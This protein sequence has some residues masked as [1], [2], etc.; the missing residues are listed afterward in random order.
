M[1]LGFNDYDGA[2]GLEIIARDLAATFL[3]RV[4]EACPERCILALGNEGLVAVGYIVGFDSR[5]GGF[6]P[7][8][9]G[10]LD[11]RAPVP[12]QRAGSRHCAFSLV[13][14][15]FTRDELAF[16]EP[17][18]PYVGNLN[19][20]PCMSRN[21]RCT[22]V[23]GGYSRFDG[24]L[25]RCGGRKRKEKDENSGQ[26]GTFDPSIVL[27]FKIEPVGFGIW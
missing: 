17:S 23:M 3:E 8:F 26:A 7:V 10:R 13:A 4:A 12:F 20:D 6:P 25:G 27:S 11:N 21:S 1:V 24:V 2:F 15:V 9:R 22:P 18:G 14:L 5:R 16:S 19:G